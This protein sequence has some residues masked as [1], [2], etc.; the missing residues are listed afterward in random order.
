MHK[1]I[2]LPL[3]AAALSTL[4]SCSTQ[5]IDSTR[6]ITALGKGIQAM[7][8]TNAQIA[9]Y[10]TQA[11]QKMDTE[12]KV[13]PASSAYA[14]RL[15]RLTAGITSVNSTPLNFKVYITND[16]NAFACADGSVRVYSGLMDIMSDDEV[17][18]IIGHEIGHVGKE[19]SK[20]AFKQ[21]L[22]NEALLDAAGSMNSKVAAITDSQ[23]AALGTALMSARYSRK[24]ENEADD[25]GYDFLKQCG[26][27]PYNMVLS[28][29]KIQ[30]LESNSSTAAAVDSYFSKMFSTHP[31]TEQ[32]I[33]HIKERCAKDGF[34][35][36]ATK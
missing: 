35:R 25:Y 22:M 11:V 36:P 19:H 27:N 14:A 21:Q 2:A 3:Y 18:G 34:S 29:E 20:N 16:V 33:S 17:L 4:T 24:Q 10:V 6:A 7:A 15:T 28:F 12:N 23:L 26:K 8:T 13:A 32:R 9:S 30:A 31:D 1:S 5:N